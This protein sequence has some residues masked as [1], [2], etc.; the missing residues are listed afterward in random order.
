[1][2]EALYF[3]GSK[4]IW[5]NVNRLWYSTV[6]DLIF[7]CTCRCPTGPLLFLIDINDIAEDIESVIKFSQMTLVLFR[8]KRSARPC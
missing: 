8:F 7:N 2:L 5:P 6:A 4:T 3:I 1:M